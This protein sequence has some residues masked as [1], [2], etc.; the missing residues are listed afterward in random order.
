MI[1]YNLMCKTFDGEGYPDAPYVVA[2]FEKELDAINSLAA[3]NRL[4]ETCPDK[5][6]ARWKNR[7]VSN[8][9]IESLELENSY[10]DF[11]IKCLNKDCSFLNK[12]VFDEKTKIETTITFDIGTLS[13][14]VEKVEFVPKKI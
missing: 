7:I 12:P 10:E 1:I 8:Y 11:I 4:I 2:S 14:K 9:Y 13:W 5:D 3:L 6:W